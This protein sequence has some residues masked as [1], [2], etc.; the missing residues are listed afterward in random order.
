VHVGSPVGAGVRGA[1][2]GTL[3]PVRATKAEAKN[4]H[5]VGRRPVAPLGHRGL[6]RLQSRI[7]NAATA[8]LFVQRQP[9]QTPTQAGG[10]LTAEQ[11]AALVHAA[12]VLRDVP[13]LAPD[14]QALLTQAIPG[15][16]VFQAIKQRD[17]KRDRLTGRTA[18]LDRMRREV[19]NPP[20]HGMPPND[21]MINEVATEVATLTEDVERLEKQVGDGLAEAGVATEAE[22]GDLVTRRF[23][24]LFF[25]RGK[26]IMLTEL[27]QNKRIVEDE[28]HRYGLDMCVDPAARESLIAAARDLV[29]RDNR[30]AELD[31]EISGLRLAVDLP[32]AGPLD[33]AQLGSSYRDLVAR[34]QEHARAAEERQ[35]AYQGYVVAH[36]ILGH[37]VDLRAIASGDTG[38]VDEAVGGKLHDITENIGDTIDNVNDDD[39]KVWSLRNAVALTAHDLGVADNALL[40]EVVAERIRA[41][42]LDEAMVRIA[43]AA[44]AITASVV[45]AIASGGVTLLAQGVAAGA[46]TVAVGASAYQLSGSISEFLAESAASEVAL[47]PAIADISTREPDLFWVVLDL[48]SF[49][50][51]AAAVVAAVGRIAG[52]IRAAIQLGE[53][54]EFARLARQVP[55]LSPAQAERL[56]AKVS[57]M[58]ASQAAN[59]EALG[60]VG[61]GAG[62]IGVTK[63][64]AEGADEGGSAAT[65]ITKMEQHV[66]NQNARLAAA[67]NASDAGYLQSI[68]MSPAQV[69]ILQNPSHGA[70]AMMYGNALEAGVARAFAADPAL[71][72]IVADT[73]R[74]THTGFRARPDFTFTGGPMQEFIVDLTT[75]GQRANKLTKYYDRV[76]VLTYDRPSFTPAASGQGR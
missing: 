73:R 36:P 39:L 24:E 44:L 53:V 69:R 30:L 52:G 13:A 11:R 70:F 43:V 75:P 26:Q 9:P 5:T 19:E 41:E 6:L 21:D 15:A 50:L 68:G 56:S 76:V 29:G 46:T 2:G 25:E 67:I 47:D 55:E 4:E 38:R 28:T 20:E 18:E 64:L 17:A 59:V 23:P 54:D 31:R 34:Q 40:M 42:E 37:G 51:D 7:G 58:A 12:T 72:G 3:E 35:T 48:I 8:A 10:A 22:L 45:A 66:A 71:A 33:P 60:G 49:G 63:I 16:V 61:G 62:R 27:A 1:R 32:D 14:R 74:V 65:I 57:T